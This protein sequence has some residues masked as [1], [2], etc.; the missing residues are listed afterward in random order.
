M[1]VDFLDNSGLKSDKVKRYGR[2][3][4]CVQKII[5]HYFF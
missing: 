3:I 4:K 2:D 5:L 1:K